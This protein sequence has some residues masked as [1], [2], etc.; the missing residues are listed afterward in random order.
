M[1]VID[2]DVTVLYVSSR[3]CAMLSIE[4]QTLEDFLPYQFKN[5]ITFN[6]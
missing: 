2:L 5:G 1:T 6:N 3:I 4:D